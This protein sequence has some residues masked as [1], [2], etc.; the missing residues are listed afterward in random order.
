VTSQLGP[1]DHVAA[2]SWEINRPGNSC[3]HRDI[4][5]WDQVIRRILL[6]NISALLDPAS[7][8]ELL[9]RASIPDHSLT[10]HIIRFAM[11]IIPPMHHFQL[12]GG[13][14]RVAWRPVNLGMRGYTNA[15]AVTPVI[16]KDTPQLTTP[17]LHEQALAQRSERLSI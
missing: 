9:F 13:E 11:S 6:T 8:L 15:P 16:Q 12:Q 14:A 3:C 1:T 4:R 10:R 7:R 2:S 17:T 5:R